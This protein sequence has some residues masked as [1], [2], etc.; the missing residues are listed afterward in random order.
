MYKSN[1]PIWRMLPN[2]SWCS[3][4]C[5]GCDRCSRLN[6]AIL[7]PDSLSILKMGLGTSWT[8]QIRR[9]HFP[10]CWGFVSISHFSAKLGELWSWDHQVQNPLK[11]KH[12]TIPAS[13]QL[14]HI[15][16]APNSPLLI[17]L[18][19]R[20]IMLQYIPLSIE[21]WM[22]LGYIVTLVQGRLHLDNTKNYTNVNWWLIG[23]IPRYCGTSF[24]T[25]KPQEVIHMVAQHPL[26]CMAQ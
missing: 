11:I 21:G 3:H 22:L 7:W 19:V 9:C 20:N 10:N 6:K 25:A 26:Y 4:H 15:P 13:Y 14:G 23:Y 5:F 2:L 12:L 16:H 24:E 17:D 18:I 1:H 8:I